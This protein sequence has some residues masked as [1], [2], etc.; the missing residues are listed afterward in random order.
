MVGQPGGHGRSAVLPPPS[1][2][3]GAQAQALVTPDK[4]VGCAHQKHAC[5]EDCFP[6]GQSTGTPGQRS[7]T[8]A[9]G[10]VQAFNV[11]GVDLM[12]APTG[13]SQH[14]GDGLQAPPHDPS[15]NCHDP[16]LG[17]G[18]DHLCE[19]QPRRAD[20]WWP[21]PLA[22]AHAGALWRG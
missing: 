14:L 20:A 6:V 21:A 4:V 9:E 12:L 2:P 1:L 10:G 8:G 22:G 15:A 17:G 18:L 13:C 11:R 5:A 3:W 7:Q 19:E 16:P